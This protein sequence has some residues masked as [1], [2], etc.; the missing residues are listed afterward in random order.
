MEITKA[1]YDNPNS[2]VL[3]SNKTNTV[4]ENEDNRLQKLAPKGNAGFSAYKFFMVRVRG[5]Y[6]RKERETYEKQGYDVSVPMSLDSILKG[7]LGM[8]LQPELGNAVMQKVDPQFENF[9]TYHLEGITPIDELLGTPLTD[10]AEIDRVMIGSQIPELM[11]WAQMKQFI[12]E[13]KLAVDARVYPNRD[14]LCYAIRLLWKDAKGFKKTQDD[15]LKTDLSKVKQQAVLAT[16]L[17]KFGFINNEGKAR[18][19]PDPVFV[20]SADVLPDAKEPTKS[21]GKAK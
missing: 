5:T 9:L 11:S 16:D 15:L 14:E 1:E 13:E 10:Q 3:T 17:E 2:N 20:S 21:K 8:F 19:E 12:K 4:P 7:P 6:A 18:V